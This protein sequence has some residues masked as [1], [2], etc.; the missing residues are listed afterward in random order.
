MNKKKRDQP[1]YKNIY[2]DIILE[3]FPEKKDISKSILKKE[4]LSILD[5]IK[6]NELISENSDKETAHF[7]QTL[8]SYDQSC[9]FEILDYQKKNK[10]NNT[11]LAQHFKLSRNTVAKWKKLFTSTYYEGNIYPKVKR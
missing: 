6:L 9:I 4:E 8:R 7:N 5:I 1:N 10:L 11:Q 3:K 2:R